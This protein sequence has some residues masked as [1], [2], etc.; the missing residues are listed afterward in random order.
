MFKN[1]LF[2]HRYTA[3]QRAPP[4]PPGFQFQQI[5]R[6]LRMDIRHTIPPL[7]PN[8]TFQRPSHLLLYII[9]YKNYNLEYAWIRQPRSGGCHYPTAATKCNVQPCRATT[10]PVSGKAC[11]STKGGLLRYI[12]N[13]YS[14]H[15]L[16]SS[17]GLGTTWVRQLRSGSCHYP[18]AATKCN[19]LRTEPFTSVY[20]RLRKL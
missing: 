3:D 15:K 20:H 12:P 19:V 10:N 13:T 2:A 11:S 6:F 14:N 1:P 9:D 17:L 7:P 5:L 4:S 16:S 8:V 18:T